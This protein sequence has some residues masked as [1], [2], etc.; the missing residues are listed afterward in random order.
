MASERPCASVETRIFSP[1]NAV[2]FWFL[3][4]ATIVA[5]SA[6]GPAY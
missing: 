3:A 1:E 6:A 4:A 2:V 5:T